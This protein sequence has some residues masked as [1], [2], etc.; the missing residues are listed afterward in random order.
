MAAGMSRTPQLRT[1]VL[2]R[3]DKRSYSLVLLMASYFC[4]YMSH[5][6]RVF[7]DIL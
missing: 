4:T 7:S 6:S 5:I 1:A 2:A 3:Y